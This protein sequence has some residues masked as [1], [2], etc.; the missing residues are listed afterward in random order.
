LGLTVLEGD[1]GYHGRDQSI[2]RVPQEIE[3][4]S[5]KTWKVGD[6]LKTGELER[7]LPYAGRAEGERSLKELGG[8][9]MICDIF[10]FSGSSTE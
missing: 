9:R 2:M 3:I 1:Y 8:T 5:F 7:Q 10:R 6:M 4:F